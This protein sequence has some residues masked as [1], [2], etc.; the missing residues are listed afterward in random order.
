P[1]SGAGYNIVLMMQA[2]S[3]HALAA[4]STSTLKSWD[5]GRPSQPTTTNPLAAKDEF[6]GKGRRAG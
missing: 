1:V 6:V 2:A 5:A 3:Q 4:K